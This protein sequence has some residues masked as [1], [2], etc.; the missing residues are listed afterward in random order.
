MLQARSR[1]RQP[2]SSVRQPLHK[3]RIWC[4]SARPGCTSCR[5]VGMPCSNESPAWRSWHITFYADGDRRAAAHACTMPLVPAGM[6][7]HSMRRF[8][9]CI[10]SVMQEHR[11][12]TS[13]ARSQLEA[14]QE[15]VLELQA[16]ITQAVG[17]AAKLRQQE[18]ELEQQVTKLTGEGLFT[19]PPLL[20]EAAHLL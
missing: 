12:A 10:A 15:S 14:Q 17:D 19:I 20:S 3:Q 2:S 6:T 7:N 8:S 16:Q 18:A 1:C 11:C 13:S 9:G 5:W 4:R